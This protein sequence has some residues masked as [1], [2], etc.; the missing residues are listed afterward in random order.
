MNY[1]VIAYVALGQ[2]SLKTPALGNVVCRTIS[3]YADIRFNL[4][5]CFKL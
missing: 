3:L 4:V 5:S 1:Y 2:K